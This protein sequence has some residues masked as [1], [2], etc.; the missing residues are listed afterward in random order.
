MIRVVRTPTTAFWNLHSHSRYSANDALPQVADM[1]EQAAA[2]GQPALGLMDHGNSAGAVQ[3]YLACRDNNLLPFPGVEL[4]LVHDRGDKHAKRSHFGVVAY[5]TE[6]YSNLMRLVTQTHRNFFHKP[7]I[8]M[9]DLAELAEQGGLHGLAATSGCYF[10]LV[11]QTLVTNGYVDGYLSGLSKMFDKY[12]VE[13]QHHNIEHPDDWDDQRIASELIAA[14]DRVG[15]PCV[16]TQDAHYLH[17]EDKVDHE[18]LK[19]L[20]AYG[21]DRDDAVF[22]GD[23]FHLADERWLQSHHSDDAFRRGLAGLNELRQAHT[24]VIPELETYHYNVPFTVANP[25]QE[26]RQLCE[27]KI[28]GLQLPKRYSELLE[29]ELGVI[30]FARM[31]G[32]LLVVKEIT[33]WC[34]AEKIYTQT[35]GSAAGSVVCWLLGITT[36]DPLQWGLR[37][38]RFVSRDRTKPPDIDLDVEH[39]HRQRLLAWLGE[40]FSVAQIGTYTT[41]SL[42]GE[43]GDRKGSLRVKYFARSRAVGEPLSSWAD[44]P[45]EDAAAVYRLSNKGL[46][47]NYGVHPAG[48]VITSSAADLL[49]LVPLMHVASSDTIV[50]QFDGHDVERLGYLKID[51]LGVKTLSVLNK[52][53]Q[54]LDRPN[55]DWIPLKDAK[56]FR[57]IS[58]GQTAGVFQLEG[59]SARR[60][61][62]DLQPT[63]IR[64][65]VAAM[66]LFRPAAMN[67]GATERFIS[68]RRGDKKIP[69]RHPFLMKV[70]KE[71]QG[72]MIYQEQVI[73]LLRALGMDPD[74]LTRFLTA[75]KASNKKVDDAQKIVA[76][77]KALIKQLCLAQQMSEVDF[78]ELW[79]DIEGFAE[80]GFNKAHSTV[81]GVTAYKCAYLATHHPL[82]FFAALLHVAAGTDKE[83]GYITAAR[84]QGVKI[85]P[86]HINSSGASYE[87]DHKTYCVRKGLMSIHRVGSKAAAAIVE[88]R[89]LGGFTSLDEFCSL[90]NHRKVTGVKAYATEHDPTVGTFGVLYESR[91][92]VGVS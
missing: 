22:P 38:E 7:L 44:V 19:R 80:Y 76:E 43:E 18:T 47:S 57:T 39:T 74:P 9:R 28:N 8:D 16:V 36:F 24:L 66:A 4:Y 13:L 49:R 56:T 35:R 92:F 51:I 1:V 67:T 86:P 3:L 68:R 53:A 83:R 70:T 12:Y 45:D 60:G 10:G 5:T 32:Y 61:V 90:V 52:A 85:K 20:V 77:S 6:G 55:L 17:Q 78:E 42:S 91:A 75:V 82:E 72:I 41:Y 88:A 14:A 59:G 25:E 71:T 33:D 84:K 89:P 21:P 79:L 62:R 65:V 63:H 2:M 73:E 37:Y 54:N 64:D 11:T 48:S 29:E 87:V 27:E 50:T 40:R 34:K 81:Y 23:G 31:A 30:E 58:K 26:L 69:E 46:I 15:L